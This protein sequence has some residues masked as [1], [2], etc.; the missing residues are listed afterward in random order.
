[1]RRIS[2]EELCSLEVIDLCGGERLGYISDL[3]IDVDDGRIRSVTVCEG[4]LFPLL[5]K[6]EGY[7]IPWCDIQCIGYD[8]VLIKTPKS[9]LCRRDVGK[10]HSKKRNHEPNCK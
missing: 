2:T 4:G 9:S 7:V 1:M 5:G 6:R 3:E 10:C 8:T